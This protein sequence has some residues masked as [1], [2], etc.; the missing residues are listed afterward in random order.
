MQ[1]TDEKDKRCYPLDNHLLCRTCHMTRLGVITGQSEQQ[2]SVGASLTSGDSYSPVSM[3]SYH[4]QTTRPPEVTSYHTYTNNGV[5]SS[6]PPGGAVYDSN[7]FG[8]EKY[9]ITD[10]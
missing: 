9:R 6:A 10:L 4:V 2:N 7:N 8:N 1:L 5:T 3:P